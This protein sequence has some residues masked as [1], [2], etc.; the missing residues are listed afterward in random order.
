MKATT[1]KKAALVAGSLSFLAGSA[2]SQTA[3]SGAGGYTTENLAVGFNLI[4][5]SL[6]D[7]VI[8]SGT[9]DS[10][11]GA[12]ITDGDV[13]FTAALNDADATYLVEILGGAQSGAVAEIASVD[14]AT[15]IT[16]DGPLG[17]GTADYQIRQAPTLDD[18]FGTSLAG[19]AFVGPTVDIVWLPDGAGGFNQYA[20]K[21]PENQYRST[22]SFFV[23][24]AK[25]ISVFY[26]DALFVQVANT[27]KDVVITG[28]VKTTDT[29]VAAN[30]G[31]NLTA[32]NA[33][34]GSTFGN[35]GME[36]FLNG[37]TFVG[38]TLDI[39]WLPDGAGG[40]SQYGFNTTANQW[41]STASFFVGDQSGTALTSGMF[42]QRQAGNGDTAGAITVPP[43]YANL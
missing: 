40:Y 34:V 6:F 5:I 23:A 39:V 38:P 24:P 25:S 19:G 29:V 17:A 43:F 14:S 16:L 12:V 21:T 20:R 31:F 1:L 22:A 2:F 42:I 13:D 9:I 8:L 36:D 33:P 11:A 28:M 37:G 26:P 30:E 10:E 32:V 27:A 4:G 3:V 7:P 41:R 18:V 35:S 15:Q